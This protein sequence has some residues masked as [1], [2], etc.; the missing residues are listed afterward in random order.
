[1]PSRKDCAELIKQ[2]FPEFKKGTID[3]ILDELENMRSKIFQGDDPLSGPAF[4][5]KVIAFLDERRFQQAAARREAAENIL[6]RQKLLN[7]VTQDQFKGDPVEAVKAKLGGT[8]RYADGGNLSV[9]AMANSLRA[10]GLN[11]LVYGLENAGDGIFEI[12]KK[13]LLDRETAQATWALDRGQDVS[14]LDQKALATAK[15]YRAVNDAVLEAKQ[16]AGSAVRRLT[17]YITKQSHDAL[18]IQ[19]AG[20]EKWFSE[21]IDKL[22]LDRTFG[23]GASV[24]KAR[25][26]MEEVFKDIVSGKYDLPASEGV[27]DEFITVNG[28]SANL[29]AQTSRSRSLHF[30]D[31]FNWFDYNQ[32]YG[33]KNLLESIVSSVNQSSRQAALMY[34]FGTNPEGAYAALKSRIRSAYKDEPAVLKAFNENESTLDQWFATAQG[35]SSAPG[36]SLTARTGQ[37]LRSLIAVSR[38]GGSF[39][40]SFGDLP[41]AM[42][43][44]RASN[45]KN[46]FENAASLLSE[47]V[48][49]FTSKAER[50]KWASRLGIYLDDLNG[51]AYAKMGADDSGPGMMSRLTRLS[52]KLSLMEFHV[53]S[54]KV[55][56]AKQLSL[57]LAD[58]VDTSFE[59]LPDRFRANLERYGIDAQDWQ[60]LNR[61]AED[62][63]GGV[64]GVTPEGVQKVPAELFGEGGDRTKF[65]LQTKLL[66]YLN[67]QANI[68]STTPGLRQQAFLL[69]GTEDEGIGV[70]ARL[71]TQFKSVPLQAV[72]TIKRVALSNPETAPRT[73]REAILQG[74][75]D[76]NGM[77][78]LMV[79]ATFAGYAAMAVKD[80]ALGKTPPDPK[81][82]KVITEAWVK[83]GA[84]GIYGDFLMGEFNRKRSAADALVGPVLGQGAT[85]LDLWSRARQGEKIG[86]D[87]VNFLMSNVPFQNTF[88][89]KGALDTLIVNQVQES[90]SPGY[91]RRKEQR[92]RQ[93]N[94]DYFML[95]PTGGR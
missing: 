82:P 15:V 17:G 87:A 39:L 91:L 22:D 54:S 50:Q 38:L 94:Q 26:A 35:F 76:I 8:A 72:D 5:E 81:S 29:S 73:L 37:N 57:E 45:G 56:M 28:R 61:A 63:E 14:G 60:H 78:Q 64:R 49:S 12:A 9:D 36:T 44:L 75:G 93:D 95:R 66:S 23:P 10:K 46:L 83:G 6:K 92:A 19:A 27:S 20:F 71:V 4:R 80:L 89:A 53:E 21:T 67:D 40:S 74:K 48:S 16:Q 59:A 2:Q 52:Q 90:L 51:A 41:A 7:F 13:G 25:S 69:R 33:S 47:Y 30:K 77:V 88:W 11:Q 55:A 79:S 58:H 3:A 62:F 86:G 42:A 65:S 34:H 84:A 31:G 68:A 43:T 85:L 32:A 1:M 18:K 70:L 24:D